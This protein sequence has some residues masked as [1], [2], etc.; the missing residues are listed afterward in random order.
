VRKAAKAEG[1]TYDEYV[2]ANI[3]ADEQEHEFDGSVSLTVAE[4]DI[5]LA[6]ARSKSKER[7]PTILTTVAAKLSNWRGLVEP[8]VIATE[9]KAALTRP[10]SADHGT[11]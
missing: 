5:E 4:D 1:K 8:V 9:P 3:A 10:N 2:K 6:I 7:K 11:I